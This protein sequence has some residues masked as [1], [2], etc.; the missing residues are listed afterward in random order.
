MEK[1][2][3]PLNTELRKRLLDTVISA[4]SKAP[5]AKLQATL[6]KQV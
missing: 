2:S 6:L 4:K 3:I 1:D 5:S